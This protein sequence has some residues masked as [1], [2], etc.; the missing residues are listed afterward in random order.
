[1]QS[2]D[3]ETM[4]EADV[5]AGLKS[6]GVKELVT[7]I[8]RCNR[9]YWDEH[10]ATLSDPL[11]DQLVEKLRKLDPNAA[12]LQNMGPS[13]P[14][15]NVLAAAAALD[16]KP[17]DRFGAA[18]SHQRAMLSLDKCYSEKDLLS[19]AKKIKGE[20][21][22]MPK[23]DGI[24]SSMRYDG[25]GRLVLAATR[26]SGS[27]GE[28]ITMNVLDIPDIPNKIKGPRGVEIEVRGEIFMRLSTF[29][30]FKGEYSNPRNLAAGSIKQKDRKKSRAK[31]LSFYAYDI[32]GPDFADEREKFRFLE[33]VGFKPE[34]YEFIAD[35]KQLQAAYE[36][37]AKARPTIDFEIDGVV[38]RASATDV[39]RNLGETGHHPRYAMAYKFQGDA[40]VTDLKDIEWSVSRTGVITPVAQLEPI[41]LSGAMIGRASLH[42]LSIFKKLGLTK[43]CRVEVTRR[44]GVIPNVEQV[45]EDGPG[46]KPFTLPTVCPCGRGEPTEVRKKGSTGEFLFC[47]RKG[48]CA[49]AIFG[50]LEHFAKVID[51]QGFG[52]KVIALAVDGGLLTSPIDFFKLK[53]KDLAG[54]ERMGVKS[55]QNLVEQ[56]EQHKQIP[57]W[58][59]LQ[60]LGI[61]TLGKQ[62]ARLLAHEF[63]ELDKIRKLTRDQ[64]VALKGVG[65]SMA[66]AIVDGLKERKK[67]IDGLLKHVS[68]IEGEP[69]PEVVDGALSGQSFV[70]TGTLEGFGRDAAQKRVR[71]LG[72]ETPSGVNKTLTYLV[73]GAGRAA[74][75]SKQKKA[76]QLINAGAPLKIITEDEFLKLTGG[77]DD[78]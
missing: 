33:A 50:E 44:G 9:E 32:I 5:R 24:A 72:G 26:G 69:E 23:M 52:P 13:A 53:V 11:Y 61:D 71:A 64:L 38:Y 19:W 56:V 41:E 7:L 18:V 60:A 21:V 22:V 66:A 62:N 48:G 67:L 1:M 63:K 6:F 77:I 57:L 15:G 51:I 37:W 46:K 25:K 10:N 39:Q 59:F 49:Q 35:R 12:V 70:F 58:V 75:S 30:K 14:T 40:G 8:S 2:T 45:S 29:Q 31:V 74:K 34:A 65:E 3:L 47:A 28:D 78:E 76:E 27:E 73:V 17:E 36:R 42:N 4:G 54:L 43:G 68:L 20:V 55:A 16:M